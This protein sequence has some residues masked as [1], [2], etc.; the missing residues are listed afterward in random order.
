MF[1][2]PFWLSLLYWSLVPS[3]KTAWLEIASIPVNSKDIVLI[4]VACLYLFLP[5]INSRQSYAASSRSQNWHCYLPILTAIMILYAAFTIQFYGAVLPLGIGDIEPMDDRTT[6]AMRL[7]LILT[8]ASFSL[9][10]TLIAKRPP[11]SVRFF[12]W[13]LTVYLAGIGLL[14]SVATFIGVEVEG[15]RSEFNSAQSVYGGLRVVGPL[16]G[17]ANGF[18]PLIPALAFCVQEFFRDRNQR[19]FKLSIMFALMITIVGLG[20]RAGLLIIGIFLAF[21]TFSMKNKKQAIV[22]IV[23]LIIIILLAGGILFAQGG[24][25]RL[26]SFEDALRAQTNLASF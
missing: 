26:T 13:Q 9:G 3:T 6:I 18:F 14:Y 5:K 12:L 1:T 11:E 21:L 23:V 8:A 22:V 10:Y 15:V 2:L 24:G 7:T 20:S 16:F 19:L 4:V 25:E 17:A